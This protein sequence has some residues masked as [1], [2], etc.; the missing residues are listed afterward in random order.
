M[1]PLY[2]AFLLSFWS[3]VAPQVPYVHSS[4]RPTTSSKSKHS[5]I[6]LFIVPSFKIRN[7][8]IFDLA[9]L[10]YSGLFMSKLS[11]KAVRARRLLLLL[12][13]VFIVLPWVVFFYLK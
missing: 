12:M 9:T 3:V 8:L 4:L 7:F 5:A 2:N 6:S 11:P 10:L 1:R 13:G